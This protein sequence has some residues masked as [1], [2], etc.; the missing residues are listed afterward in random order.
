MKHIS[1]NTPFTFEVIHHR[2]DGTVFEVEVSARTVL[3]G[4]KTFIISIERDITERKKAEK[5]FA[6]VNEK[7]RVIG[8]LTRHDVGNKMAVA[9]ANLFL[10][11]NKATCNPELT[12][13][14]T[15]IEETL[16]ESSRIL[17][18]GKLYEKIGAEK[19]GPIIVET[20]FSEAANLIPHP[21]VK[22][23]NNTQGLTVIADAL[24][25]QL[26]YNL[27][28]NSL[29]HGKTTTGIKLSYTQEPNQTILV[30]EDNGVGVPQESK[31]KIFT[32]GF[33]TGGSGLGLKLARK[34]VEVYG[35]KIKEEGD[36][37]K[38]AKFVI[39]IPKKDTNPIQTEI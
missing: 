22:I 15:A 18:F 26:F 13:Y 38:G 12:K 28:D 33:T 17:E 6:S 31:P 4:Q 32:D 8:S 36:P 25:R 39:I 9:K 27:I 19:L 34:M 1:Q 16:N 29:K 35:W 14:I 37:G 20:E 21:S 7:L 5:Q 11:K 10:L 23:I 30:Y 24:L 2:K 3:V